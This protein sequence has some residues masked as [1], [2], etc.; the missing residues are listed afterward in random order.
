MLVCPPIAYC[1]QNL[2]S[3]HANTGDIDIGANASAE[4]GEEE[5]EDG[6]EIVNNVIHGFRLNQVMVDLTTYKGHIKGRRSNSAS[7]YLSLLTEV[8]FSVRIYYE[9]QGTPRIQRVLPRTD[10]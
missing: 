2:R 1:T 8:F 4:G 9:D 10:T 7:F 5:L 6:S 3:V